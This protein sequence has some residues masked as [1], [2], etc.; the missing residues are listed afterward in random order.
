MY[1]DDLP[2]P[3]PNREIKFEINLVPGIVPILKALYQ[4]ALT[5]LK[6]LKVHLQ[7]L[8]DM[9]QIQLSA[10]LWEALVF[11]VKKKNGSF[12]LCIDYCKLNKVT[13][14]NKYP[15]PRIDDLF[16]Q[17]KGAK[18]FSKIDLRFEYY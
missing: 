8:L 2:E 17:L 1:P 10:S 14:K 13:I 9:K 6:E 15:L 16:E 11:F 4:M 7:E 3:S 18:V 12:R 5:K